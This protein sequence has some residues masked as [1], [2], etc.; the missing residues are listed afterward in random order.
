VAGA[1]ECQRG[2]KADEAWC[3][4]GQQDVTERRPLSPY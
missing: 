1:G 2:G 4:S 3:V